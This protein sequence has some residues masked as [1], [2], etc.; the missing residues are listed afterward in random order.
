[1]RFDP[2]LLEE[3]VFRRMNAADTCAGP[4]RR[5]WDAERARI[6]EL[7]PAAQREREFSALAGRWFARLGL[8]RMRDVLALTPHLVRSAAEIRVRRAS[9]ARD[10]GSELYRGGPKVR[11]VLAVHAERFADPAAGNELCLRECLHAEDMLDPAFGYRPALGPDLRAGEARTELVRDRLRVLWAAR[12]RG[13]AAALLGSRRD[14]LPPAAFR[15]AFSAIGD[16]A[17]L[18]ALH[19]RAASGALATFPEL[20]EAARLGL[21]P[22]LQ[23][24]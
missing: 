5:A 9:G 10:E 4:E 23:P 19:E 24:A 8:D 20:L 22:P 15:R 6:Y 1:V 11:F 2:D 16:D 17:A 7:A 21:A 18:R 14:E 13:R 12:V 3:A